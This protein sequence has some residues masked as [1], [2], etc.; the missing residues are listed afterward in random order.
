MRCRGANRLSSTCSDSTARSSA[1]S[2]E[3]MGTSSKMDGSHG[4]ERHLLASRCPTRRYPGHRAVRPPVERR[5]TAHT[6]KRTRR[7]KGGAPPGSGLRASR[8]G[9]T[10]PEVEA[11][12]LE[13]L[14]GVRG[15]LDVLLHPV[16][17]VGLDHGNPRQVLEEDLGDLSIRLAPE[18]LVHGEASGVAELVELRLAPI[19][20]RA[21]GAKEAPHHAVGIA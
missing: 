6:D 5:R 16:V 12:D 14:V 15:E 20:H 3:K 21:P 11:P 8:L 2:S 7:G 13:L 18:L 1:S 17:L 19:V 9:A 4:I 10:E